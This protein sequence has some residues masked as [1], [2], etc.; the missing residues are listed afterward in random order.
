VNAYLINWT[1]QGSSTNFT[2]RILSNVSISPPPGYRVPPTIAA[3][4]DVLGAY[5]PKV[6]IGVVT[7]R[8]YFAGVYGGNLA[9]LN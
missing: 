5:D 3:A 1:E 9:A 2:S 6:G 8:F 4:Q 7:S